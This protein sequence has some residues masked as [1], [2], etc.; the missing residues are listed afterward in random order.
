MVTERLLPFF[1]ALS[2]SNR[3]KIVGLL[4]NRPHAVE[5][6]AASLDL[7]PST[8]SHHL[9][10]LAEAGLVSARAEGHYNVYQLELDSLR[11]TARLLLSEETL[12]AIASD[13]DIGA[14]QRKV[15]RNFL[16]PDGRLKDIPS[17]RK[18]RLIILEHLVQRFQPGTIY[19]EARVNE[20]LSQFH[21]DTATLRRELVGNGLML[22]EEGQYWRQADPVPGQSGTPSPG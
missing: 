4:A 19:P 21:E 11:E 1:K 13:V 20:V 8:I 22:R 5:E 17:Q 12:P 10:R 7:K 9:S 16:L 14:Y 18:K 3:L 2:D 15:L 6:L